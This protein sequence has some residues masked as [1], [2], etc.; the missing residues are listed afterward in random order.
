MSR[1]PAAGYKL[2]LIP[3][4]GWLGFRQLYKSCGWFHPTADSGSGGCIRVAADYIPRLTRVPA[5]DSVPRL[6]RVPAAGY[7]LQ[8]TRSRGW[9][10]F[11][12]LDASCGWFRPTT[13]S[14]SSGWI[15]LKA[16]SILRL[17]WVPAAW[18]EL[19]LILSCGWLEFY[20]LTCQ[21]NSRTYS[22][23]YIVFMVCF[24]PTDLSYHWSRLWLLL[25]EPWRSLRTLEEASR[26]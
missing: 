17:T 24:L 12:R 20:T 1:V 5:T 23:K 18:Y 7:E 2:R 15:R 6:T 14:S 25:Q 19:Q 22:A 13:D 9:L 10:K 3:S 26:L 21:V 11:Q 4:Y 8:L 16:D